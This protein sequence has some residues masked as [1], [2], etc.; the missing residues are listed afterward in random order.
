MK[1]DYVH[2]LILLGFIAI[3]LG[4]FFW[5][6]SVVLQ[7]LS[8]LGVVDLQVGKLVPV[9][10]DRKDLLRIEEEMLARKIKEIA[11]TRPSSLPSKPNIVS[12]STS[13]STAQTAP[14]KK[15]AV[16]FKPVI[17]TSTIFE[18]KTAESLSS[19]TSSST[20]STTSTST[21]TSIQTSAPVRPAQ[22]FLI[23]GSGFCNYVNGVSTVTLVGYPLAADAVIPHGNIKSWTTTRVIFTTP[24][25]VPPGTFEVTI[26]GRDSF[27]YCTSATSSPRTITVK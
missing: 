4:V 12:A 18:S 16:S 19:E 22:Q 1:G 9:Q 21:Q 8:P 25:W 23:D 2:W 20:M 24:D 10:S 6:R 26:R 5:W 13:T 3:L 11:A 15:P 17:A 27:G 7:E 14:V